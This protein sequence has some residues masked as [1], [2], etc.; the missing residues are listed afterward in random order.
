VGAQRRVPTALHC[1]RDPVFKPGVPV[2]SCKLHQLTIS[3][4]PKVAPRS[5]E[6]PP[7]VCQYVAMP[8]QQSNVAFFD[9]ANTQHDFTVVLR[10]Y[11]REQ[12][13]DFVG[14]LNAQ[15]GQTEQARSEAEQRMNDAQ[16]RLRQAEQ[17]LNSVEQ[18]L[19]DTSKQLEENSRRRSLVSVRGSSRSC[20]SR[21]SRPTTTAASPSA[22]PKASSQPPASKPV[23]SPTRLVP[24]PPP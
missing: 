4:A 12:V 19:T 1:R 2:R 11:D 21:R 24:R 9:G 8:Q 23:R 10:G 5:C 14:R 16:R 3:L 17:R 20:A 7:Y 13:N 6:A 22:S 18:K 15:L